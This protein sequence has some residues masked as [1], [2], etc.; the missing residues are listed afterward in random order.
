[1]KENA[2][3]PPDNEAITLDAITRKTKAISRL[4]EAESNLIAAQHVLYRE[5]TYDDDIE[6][7]IMD[8]RSMVRALI[9]MVNQSK[10][11]TQPAS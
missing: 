8:A 7:A 10:A 11:G 3:H 2:M 4:I 1:M 9:F 5:A 6:R